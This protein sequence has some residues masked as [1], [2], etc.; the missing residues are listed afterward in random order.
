MLQSTSVPVNPR[1]R[2]CFAS[3]AQAT[4]ICPC[5]DWHFSSIL[6]LRKNKTWVVNRSEISFLSIYPPELLDFKKN[7]RNSAQIRSSVRFFRKWRV[8]FLKF[9]Y[10]EHWIRTL[11]KICAEKVV[12][13]WKRIQ[14][15]KLFEPR[16][17]SGPAA[18][19]D[20]QAPSCWNYSLLFDAFEARLHI[21]CPLFSQQSAAPCL[22]LSRRKCEI[23]Q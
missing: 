21:A 16:L 23:L 20:P 4:R 17:F 7:I 10:F 1:H 14:I 11:L 8:I 18:R 22:T 13:S 12:F 6:D 3:Q 15:N 5:K 19:A 2:P 9:R